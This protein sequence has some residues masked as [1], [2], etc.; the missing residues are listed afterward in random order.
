M[1]SCYY[2]PA[3][4]IMRDGYFDYMNCAVK[5]QS[6]SRSETSK[7]SLKLTKL[8]MTITISE[9]VFEPASFRHAIL[10]KQIILYLVLIID[11]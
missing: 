11:R 7:V 4:D 3:L 6:N 2:E 5:Q 8:K 10:G 1:Q 9:R